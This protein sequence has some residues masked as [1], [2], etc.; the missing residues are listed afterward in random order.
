MYNVYGKSYAVLKNNVSDASAHVAHT[1]TAHWQI[2][3]T[4]TAP[5]QIA[6]TQTAP[7]QI[8]HT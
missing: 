3:H 8:A 6:H 4:Q 2:A 7:T 1:Q 5:T